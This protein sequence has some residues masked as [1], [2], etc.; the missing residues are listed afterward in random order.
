MYLTEQNSNLHEQSGAD[1]V[2]MEG[3]AFLEFFQQLETS[4]AILRVVSDDSLHDIPDVTSAINS[5]GSLQPLPLALALIRQPLSATWLI[6]GSL[7]GL[8][9]FIRESRLLFGK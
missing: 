6:R 7:K 9:I 5:D 2:D 4:V 1:L 3:F 8:K